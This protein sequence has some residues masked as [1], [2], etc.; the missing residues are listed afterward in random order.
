VRGLR[1][2]HPDFEVAD[3]PLQLEAALI[4]EAG[5]RATSIEAFEVIP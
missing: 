3:G 1:A 2:L 5:G 4:T